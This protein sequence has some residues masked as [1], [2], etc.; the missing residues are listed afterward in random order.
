MITCHRRVIVT[1]AYVQGGT[2]I[3][4]V[5]PTDLCLSKISLQFEQSVYIYLHQH[6]YNV[7]KNYK[8]LV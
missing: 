8:D 4:V 6:F 3:Q 7:D 2:E 5:Y 1:E